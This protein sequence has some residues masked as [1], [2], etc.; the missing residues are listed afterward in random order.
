MRGRPTLSREQAIEFG[1][2]SRGYA[3]V[4]H[5]VGWHLVPP[6]R[7]PEA[8]GKMGSFAL[9]LVVAANPVK[10]LSSLVATL[11]NQVEVLIGEVD[12]VNAARISGV[13]VVD[14]SFAVLGEDTQALALREPRILDDVVVE[15]FAGCDLFSLE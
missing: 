9:V 2:S 7:L 4:G 11:W 10:S 12:H 6:S 14:V 1:L 13:S 5:C 8:A 15:C 3:I